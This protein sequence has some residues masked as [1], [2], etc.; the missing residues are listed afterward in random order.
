MA[1]T[2]SNLL[3]A[4]VEIRTAR[5]NMCDSCEFKHKTIPLCNECKCLI[6]AKVLLTNATCPKDKWQ[7]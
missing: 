7:Q 5:K 6:P 4:P 1:N 3:I 2:L